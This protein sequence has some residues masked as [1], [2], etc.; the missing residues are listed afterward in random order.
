M[1]Q[2]VE[3]AP[4]N[5]ILQF[6][7]DTPVLPCASSMTVLPCAGWRTLTSLAFSMMQRLCSRHCV[8]T[9]QL[10]AQDHVPCWLQQHTSCIAGKGA[11]N[12]RKYFH[13]HK[14]MLVRC[15][16]RYMAMLMHIVQCTRS[17]RRHGHTLLCTSG[18]HQML[19]STSN[20]SLCLHACLSSHAHPLG[21]Q[22]CLERARVLAEEV[23]VQ[24]KD[25]HYALHVV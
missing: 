3:H 15:T 25:S 14:Q 11:Q 1:Q 4:A 9:A 13:G 2:H 23:I 5:S 20:Q 6:Y 12:M 17:C 16:Y 8:D 10:E 24:A 19:C 22:A 18:P 7:T 21:N